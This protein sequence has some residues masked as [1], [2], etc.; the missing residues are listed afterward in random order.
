[1]E[2]IL[3]KNTK[4]WLTV[5]RVVMGW[6]FFYAGITKIL[7]PDWSAAGFLNNA[8]TFSGLY[9]WFAGSGVIGIVNFVNEW[10]L[11]LLGISLI[12]GLFVRWGAIPGAILMLLYYFAGNAFPS[13]PNGF[14]VD[15]HIIYAV[16]LILF[17]VINAGKYFGLDG[18]LKKDIS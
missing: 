17:F 7:N 5:A 15:D 9:V 3:S 4:I 11:T 2:N 6:L 8:K 10:A 1:M 14:I 16:I 12:L 18:I 13:V